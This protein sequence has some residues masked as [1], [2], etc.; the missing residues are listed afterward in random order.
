MVIL[1]PGTY[2][3]CSIV[4]AGKREYGVLALHPAVSVRRD[5]AHEDTYVYVVLTCCTWYSYLLR[6]VGSLAALISTMLLVLAVPNRAWQQ[7]LRAEDRT[8]H[9]E[10]GIVSGPARRPVEGSVRAGASVALW[11]TL[12]NTLGLPFTTQAV[13]PRHITLYR[14]RPRA[15]FCWV[16]DRRPGRRPATALRWYRPGLACCSG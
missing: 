4:L 15:G 12:C 16:P 11:P 5:R 14:T 3:K 10:A 2:C 9:E 7:R 8:E 1:R 6:A 13:S